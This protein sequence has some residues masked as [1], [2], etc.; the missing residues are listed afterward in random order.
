MRAGS[1]I[2]D[3]ASSELGGNV[4]VS[5]PG[6]RFRT[7]NGV[8]VIGAGSLAAQMPASASAMYARNISTLLLHLVRD[9]ELAIDPAD[10]IQSGVVITYAGE[11]IQPAT[12][13]LVE[14]L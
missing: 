7:D 4:E 8:T 11:V 3:M 13:K 9:G 6:E 14:N 12:R 5:R 2:V 1:V 10:E